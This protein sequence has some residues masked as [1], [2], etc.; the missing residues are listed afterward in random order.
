MRLRQDHTAAERRRVLSRS[1]RAAEKR[2]D[3]TWVC[4]IGWEG[5]RPRYF[6]DNSGAWPVRIV[7]TKKDR[8]AAKEADLETP[9]VG[10]VV[11]EKVAVPTAE[12]A[13]RLK[14][15]LDKALLGEVDAKGNE[16]MRHAWRDLMG[17]WETGDDRAIWW[18]VILEDALR[19][20]KKQAREFEIM[21][22]KERD[23]RIAASARRG[24]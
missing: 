16:A 5:P 14:A 6:G 9:H 20:V 8:T 1:M 21:D 17:C 22:G 3:I 12:H 24:R 15:A 10:V 2:S 7:T 4:L 18:G 23:R 13:K 11:L 19:T